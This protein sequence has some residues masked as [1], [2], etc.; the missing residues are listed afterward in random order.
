MITYV[1]LENWKSYRNFELK[2]DRGTT[3]LVAANGVG[4]T[5]FIDAVQWAL[6]RGAAPS[7]AMM[8]KRAKTTSVVVE[9]IAGDA[10]IRVKRSLKLGRAKAPAANLE[11]WI[12]KRSVE[13]DEAFQ[14]LQ[15]TWR[16]DNR[17]SSRAAFLTDR[18]REKDSEPDLRSHLTRLHALD[19]VQDAIAA[20]GSAI[21]SATE[22]ADQARKDTRASEGELQQAINDELAAATALETARS[23]LENLR[24]EVTIAANELSAGQRTNQARDDHSAWTAR[25]TEIVADA[26]RILGTMPEDTLLGVYLRSA[27]AGASQQLTQ[28]TEQRGR[29]AERVAALEESLGRLR[30]SEGECPVCRRPLDDE[31]RTHAE[32]AHQ[33]DRE[34]A[35]AE[36][37]ALDVDTF[38]SVASTLRRLVQRTE[39]LGDA[40]PVPEGEPVDLDALSTRLD[41]VK[42]AFETA[43]GDARQAELV[44]ANSTVRRNDL[45]TQR[46]ATSSVALY[47]RVAALETAR[48]ALKGTVTKVLEAQ[49]GPVSDEVNRRWEA[50]FPDRPGLRLDSTGQMARIF[51]DEEE[52]ID[53]SS[54]SSGEKVVAKLLLRLAT[55]TSTTEIPFCWIDEPLEHL[56]PDARSYVAQMLAYLS[57]ADALVRS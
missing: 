20:L 5:S 42:A 31:S 3:F 21:K 30:T 7:R 11:A 55:L 24:A 9:V 35:T 54:F 43:L 39:A 41:E 18:F 2:L 10:T 36:L 47:T 8:R 1:S 19:H 40:P 26:E 38:V 28:L 15:D 37:Q 34:L 57:S 51:D 14:W 22:V 25:R 29:L 50:V 16:V 12:D 27:E 45:E 52:E 46:N 53:F 49:L 56:D 4:K 33:H 13:P 44:A 48:S 32:E 23:Q 6:D 17:F